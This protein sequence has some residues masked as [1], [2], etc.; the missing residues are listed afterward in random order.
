MTMRYLLES[1]YMLLYNCNIH[2]HIVVINIECLQWCL[3]KVNWRP[4]ESRNY[5]LVTRMSKAVNKQCI[6][7]TQLWWNYVNLKIQC[8]FRGMLFYYTQ[9]ERCFFS[10][11]CCVS[12]KQA[13]Q[14]PKNPKHGRVQT[15]ARMHA[16]TH[17]VQCMYSCMLS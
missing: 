14:T 12:R 10:S 6:N 11:F 1:V 17:I 13:Q 16:L 15:L 5:Y 7:F 3:H 4:H 8:K 9:S 2:F